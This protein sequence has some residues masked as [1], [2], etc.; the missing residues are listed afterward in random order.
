MRNDEHHAELHV[1]IWTA[2]SEL[3]RG[4]IW[5]SAYTTPHSIGNAK[6]AGMQQDLDLSSSDYS[7]AVSIFFIGYLLLQIPS[8][9][10]LAKTKPRLYLPGIMVSSAL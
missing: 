9:M 10:I 8:N 2:T 4:S 1:K 6:T 7:L 3:A 5:K